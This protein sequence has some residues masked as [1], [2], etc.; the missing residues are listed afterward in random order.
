MLHFAVISN[1]YSSLFWSSC[2]WPL[3]T[4][5]RNSQYHV[6]DCIHDTCLE[7]NL[8]HQL[9]TTDLDQIPSVNSWCSILPTFKYQTTLRHIR[10]TWSR[11]HTKTPRSCLP[12]E[13]IT[14]HQRPR[15]SPEAASKATLWC[16]HLSIHLRWNDP[17]RI[18]VSSISKALKKI[19]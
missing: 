17:Q 14:E 1:F 8:S 6:H 12:P 16:G 9:S 10:A 11:T 15:R 2:T 19:Y 3:A 18:R 7:A 5:S 13:V 4:S